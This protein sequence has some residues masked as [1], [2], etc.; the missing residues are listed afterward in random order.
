MFTRKPLY[1]TSQGLIWW[2]DIKNTQHRFN[3]K[4]Q[5]QQQQQLLRCCWC[6]LTTYE[7]LFSKGAIIWY[8]FNALM[9][10]VLCFEVSRNLESEWER[11]RECGINP[12]N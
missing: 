8:E 6:N 3:T 10:V 7:G 1:Y 12:W 5:Q 4:P 11:E 2:D 9:C